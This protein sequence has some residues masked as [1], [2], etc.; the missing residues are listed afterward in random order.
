MSHMKIAIV[1]GTGNISQPI[2]KLLLAQGHDV[3]C[4]NRG[5]SRPVQAGARLITCD[6]HDCDRFERAMQAEHFDA[7][8]DMICFNAEDAASSVRA[9]RGVG[10]FVQTSTVNTYGP[11]YDRLPADETHPL[12]PEGGYAVPKAAAD[13]V[14]L[15]AWH[16]EKFPVVIIKPSTSYGPIQGMLR[17][18]AWEFSWIDRICKGKPVIVCGDGI[19]LH[20]HLHVEDIAHAFAGVIGKEHTKGQIYN[21]VNRG[22]ISWADYHRTAGRVLGREAELVGVPLDTLKRCGVPKFDICESWFSGHRYYAADK[23]FRDVPEFCPRISLEQGMAQVF[24]AMA[25]DGRIPNSDEL[26][27]EDDIIRQ[28]RAVGR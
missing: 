18:V 8:I 10:W 25:R 21:A 12:R 9:F 23:L 20:Q 11:H 2:V 16:A 19:A 14:Y 6:R 5:T 28:Q 27:W 4:V 1:G 17:Q 15:A 26:T 22:F 7:A 24:D 13:N 3:T